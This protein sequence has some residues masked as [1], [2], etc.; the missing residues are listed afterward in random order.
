MTKI[1]LKNP[2][3]DGNMLL[4]GARVF[5]LTLDGEQRATKVCKSYANMVYNEQMTITITGDVLKDMEVHE[6]HAELVKTSLLLHQ[7]SVC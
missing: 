7:V 4:V 2:A 3:T 5:T 1:H 6:I